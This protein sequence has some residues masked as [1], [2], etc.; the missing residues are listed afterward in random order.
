MHGDGCTGR[1]ADDVP[2]LIGLRPGAGRTTR[3][4]RCLLEEALVLQRRQRG[5]V[6]GALAVAHEQNPAVV[7]GY[8]QRRVRVAVGWTVRSAL[9]A[10]Q[11][12]LA[13][14]ARIR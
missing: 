5:R 4:G 10:L 8:V 9:A 13:L 7:I 11:R 12:L 1:I 14:A 3:L 2:R 6:V